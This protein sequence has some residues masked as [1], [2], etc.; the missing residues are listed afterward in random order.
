[1]VA[2]STSAAAEEWL[3]KNRADLLIL[4]AMMRDVDG[5]ECCRAPLP[6]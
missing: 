2:A 5:W 1:M 4:D 3:A 6:A